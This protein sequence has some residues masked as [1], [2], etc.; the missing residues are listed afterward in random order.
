MTTLLIGGTGFLGAR[1]VKNLVKRNEK[2]VCLD[3][4]PNKKT[5]EGVIDK[6]KLIQGDVN[7]GSWMG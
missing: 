6:V 5:I 3:A 1:I 4:F 2:V 7:G